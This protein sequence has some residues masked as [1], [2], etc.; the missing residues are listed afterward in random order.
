MTQVAAHDAIAGDVHA[1]PEPC[2]P[3]TT[4]CRKSRAAW[5]GATVE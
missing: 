2:V 3:Q 4:G 1:R 5:R